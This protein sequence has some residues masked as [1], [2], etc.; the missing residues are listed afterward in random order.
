M[1]T[2]PLSRLQLAASSSTVAAAANL[3]LLLP[4]ETAAALTAAVAV[5]LDP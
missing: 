4:L 1:D 2:D 5:G 3:P